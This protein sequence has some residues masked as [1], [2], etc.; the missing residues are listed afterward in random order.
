MLVISCMVDSCYARRAGLR[1]DGYF[2]GGRLT[3]AERASQIDP[4]MAGAAAAAVVIS[5][6]VLLLLRRRKR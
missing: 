1:G 4:V 2:P 3:E 6:T 5:V